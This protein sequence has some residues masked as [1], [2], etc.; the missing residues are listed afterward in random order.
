M[1]ICIPI[2]E[3]EGLRSQMCLHFSAAPNYIIVNTDTLGYRIVP[4][5]DA[6]F[7]DGCPM[8][9]LTRE[10]VD[11][12]IVGGIGVRT[13]GELRAVGIDVVSTTEESVEDIVTSFC[14][15]AA[16]PVTLEHTCCFKSRGR[17]FRGPGG[18]GGGLCS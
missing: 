15:G 18:C 4:G 12:V 8:S 13:L 17:G 10:R 5:D 7:E 6:S 11:S 3:D 14:E 16:T 9:E 1:N 2:E